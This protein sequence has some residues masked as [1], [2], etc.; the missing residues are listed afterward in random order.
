MSEGAYIPTELHEQAGRLERAF[1]LTT[2]ADDIARKLR[3]AVK[4]K[5]LP[6]A[7]PDRLVAEAVAQGVITQAEAALLQRAEEARTEAIQV[8]AFTLEEYKRS[9]VYP[10]TSGGDGARAGDERPVPRAE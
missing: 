4:Q 8:D 2:E 10:D 9:A 7:A 6:K 3:T 5:Q 1:R